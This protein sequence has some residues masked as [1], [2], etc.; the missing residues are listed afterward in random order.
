MDILKRFQERRLRRPA[1]VD[2]KKN[3]PRLAGSEYRQVKLYID[4]AN[5]HA[6][7]ETRA[8][9]DALVEKNIAH[10]QENGLKAWSSNIMMSGDLHSCNQKS[11][12]LQNQLLFLSVRAGGTNRLESE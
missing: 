7:N 2:L 4:N 6:P 9:I 8:W 12:S 10:H 5:R 3:V 11:A 1:I